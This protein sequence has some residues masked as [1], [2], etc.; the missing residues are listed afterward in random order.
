MPVQS[1]SDGGFHVV[2]QVFSNSSQSHLYFYIYSS[3]KAFLIATI[4][5]VEREITFMEDLGICTH[6][7]THQVMEDSDSVPLP[8]GDSGEMNIPMPQDM[9]EMKM[10]EN[11]MD[12]ILEPEVAEDTVPVAYEVEEAVSQEFSDSEENSGSLKRPASCTSPSEDEP[13][14]KKRNNEV[15]KLWNNVNENPNDFQAWTLLLQHIDQVDL[16]S[17]SDLESGREAYASFFSRYPYCYGY[18]K[19]YADLEKRKGTH[20]TTMQVFEQGIRGVSLSVD[21]WLHY[22][23]FVMEQYTDNEEFVRQ[24]F[25]RAIDVCGLD[26]KSDKLWEM[27]ISWESAGKRWKNVT[28]LYERLLAT[29]L[30][31]YLTHWQ[32]FKEH[33]RSHLPSEVVGVDE[34]L[35][36]R[37][38]VLAELNGTE[39]DNPDETPPGVE[40]APGDEQ[41][42]NNDVETKKLRESIIAARQ[43]IHDANTEEVKSRWGYEEAIKR[44]YFHVKP[45]EKSQL[46]A[47]RV[48]L[49]YEMKKETDKRIRVLFERC[50]IACALYEEFWMK[51]ITYLEEQGCEEDEVRQVYHRAC[52]IHLRDS[53]KPHLAWA[54]FEEQ[55]GYADRSLEILKDVRERVIGGLEAWVQSAGV[56]RRRGNLDAA[57]NLYLTCLEDCRNMDN[58]PSHS[59]M[60]LKYARF[61][62]LFMGDQTEALQVLKQAREFDKENS[63]LLLNIADISLACH[64][65]R[66]E[67]A[68][69]A[70]KAGT[71]DSMAS[72]VR[73]MFAH[74]YMHFLNEC[75]EDRKSIKEGQQ[76]LREVQ[77]DVMAKNVEMMDSPSKQSTDGGGIAVV[78]TRRDQKRS[79]D[80]NSSSGSVNGADK[81]STT[82]MNSQASNFNNSSN[83][84]FQQSYGPYQGY[85]PGYGTPHYQSWGYPPQQG[86][87]GYNQ[88]GWGNYSNY[89]GQR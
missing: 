51:Y 81:N 57:Q 36:L 85:G 43:K 1:L 49:D 63:T 21:L 26:F 69:Q 54:A 29:P 5:S 48:Y 24:L 87:Y 80:K 50:L 44:P 23:T 7:Y 41:I 79:S 65:P 64:P 33:V 60:S 46:N 16:L 42:G 6:L 19:K 70:L 18:W 86:G 61:L 68:A 89:Y 22:L 12:G 83:N 2:D 28:L 71:E 52:N 31:K 53:L 56:E 75:G 40:A 59:N 3:N 4:A 66:L 74:R 39:G 88:Q 45:L 72:E 62:W 73:I 38:A 8:D 25:E 37:R 10:D 11:T 17:Q 32:K 55:N 76:L 35:D 30:C 13:S 34:F 15:E 84:N 20:E 9:G 47:W 27:Y 82:S 58:K 78:E 14:A 67:E 77:K